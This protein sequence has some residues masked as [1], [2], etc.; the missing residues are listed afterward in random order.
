MRTAQRRAARRGAERGARG[1][2]A[3]ALPRPGRPPF[4]GRC[5]GGLHLTLTN[6]KDKLCRPTAFFAQGLSG[7]RPGGG[8][9]A[10]RL[11]R[12]TARAP[13]APSG[14][15]QKAAPRVARGPAAHGVPLRC[16]MCAQKAPR[17]LCTGQSPAALQAAL[18][19]SLHAAAVSLPS[20][21]GSMHSALAPNEP[22]AQG[23]GLSS[24]CAISWMP[25]KLM[26][27]T[28]HSRLWRRR[29]RPMI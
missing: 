7:G 5:R 18:P 6:P 26:Q 23:S 29:A 16:V 1:R 22:R 17:I 27:R 20:T 14:R 2:G 25:T 3:A 12:L 9:G 10:R 8:V 4:A 19:G 28:A 24:R 13:A 21:P 15:A 11:V